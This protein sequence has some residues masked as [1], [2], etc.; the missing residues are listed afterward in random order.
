[1]AS[2]KSLPEFA[3]GPGQS[4]CGCW[5]LGCVGDGTARRGDLLSES[6]FAPALPPTHTAHRD[7]LFALDTAVRLGHVEVLREMTGVAENLPPDIT[8]PRPARQRRLVLGVGSPHSQTLPDRGG[9]ADQ[10]DVSIES[11]TLISP[12]RNA[13]SAL[14]CSCVAGSASRW[15]LLCRAVATR[16][17]HGTAGNGCDAPHCQGRR[18]GCARPR[19]GLRDLAYPRMTSRVVVRL[20]WARRFRRATRHALLSVRP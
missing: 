12:L 15:S 9:Y 13:S 17:Q 20:A 14:S 2:A 6:R 11:V 8:P 3:D 18:R 16:R 1:M 10:R 19:R 5:I 7:G 4:D